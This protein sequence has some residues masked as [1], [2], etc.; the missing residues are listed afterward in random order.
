MAEL[1]EIS[2]GLAC[3]FVVDVFSSFVVVVF[4]AADQFIF[5]NKFYIHLAVFGCWRGSFF[6]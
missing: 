3:F 5:G 6:K 4:M 1:K 2:S